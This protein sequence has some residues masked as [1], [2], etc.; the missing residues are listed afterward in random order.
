MAKALNTCS[1]ET[2]GQMAWGRVKF[3]GSTAAAEEQIVYELVAVFG[4][5]WD[6][7]T[8]QWRAMIRKM[9]GRPRKWRNGSLTAVGLGV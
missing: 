5:P 8:D 4:Q 2:P 9:Q 3:L 7:N 1:Y 6:G